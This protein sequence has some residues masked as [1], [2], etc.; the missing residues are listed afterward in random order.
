[1]VSTYTDRL[2]INKQ[3]DGDNDSTWGQVVNTQF[4]LFEDSI[5]AL[6]TIDLT[7]AG[8][9]RSLTTNNGS[10]DEARSA[11]L[12]ILGTPTSVVDVVIPSQT[13]HYF[14]DSLVSGANRVQI[15]TDSFVTGTNTLVTAETNRRLSIICD[16]ANV[17]LISDFVTRSQLIPTPSGGGH[18]I[19]MWSGSIGTIP[20]GWQVCDGTNNT[21]D[22]RDRFIKGATSTDAVDTGLTGGATVID[23]SI[24][25]AHNHGGTTGLHTLISSQIPGHQH[26]LFVDFSSD[27]GGAIGSTSAA[28]NPNAYVRAGASNLISENDYQLRAAVSAVDPEEGGVADDYL[29]YPPNVGRSSFAY[30]TAASPHQH[31]LTSL[32]GHAHN[33]SIEPPYYKLYFIAYVGN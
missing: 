7:G 16:G 14:V 11:I 3:G 28:N 20:S 32:D 15:R 1:M 24:A 9:T 21:P 26:Y 2:R 6:T 5:A 8:G 19:I 29:K 13:K 33:V 17:K 27:T 10:S 18:A 4:E 22:L 23:T 31:T 12:K 30:S 25:G